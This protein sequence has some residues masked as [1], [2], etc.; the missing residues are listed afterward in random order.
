MHQ[1]FYNERIIYLLAST[2]AKDSAPHSQVSPGARLVLGPAN[3]H[4]SSRVAGPGQ[5]GRSPTF[6]EIQL[7]SDGLQPTSD[8]LQFA[9]KQLTKAPY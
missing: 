5:H 9:E 8:G 4:G 3:G 1:G 6:W 7:T 2:M